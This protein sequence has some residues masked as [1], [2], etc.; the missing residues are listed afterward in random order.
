MRLLNAI[1]RFYQK[2]L[3]NEIVN[4][5][6]IPDVQAWDT[7]LASLGKAEDY[8]DASYKKYLCRIY[9]YSRF[10]RFFMNFTSFFVL[11]AYL[12]FLVKS[13]KTLS[14]PV[15]GKALFE[16]NADVGYKD[17]F[18]SQLNTEYPLIVS[19]TRNNLYIG[20]LCAPAKELYRACKK[21]HPF[22]FE[23][24]LWLVKELARHSKYL[25]E[26]N[27]TATIVY[28]NERNVAAPLLKKLYEDSGRKLISFMHGEYLFQLALAY[29]AFS[30]YYFWD[31]FYLH[32]FA[33]RER[34]T[35][36]QYVV[37]LP[38]R[39]KCKQNLV[40]LSAPEIF[41]TYYCSNESTQTITAL[42]DVI[43]RIEKKGL[44]CKVRPHPRD[45]HTELLKN[46][47]SSEQIELPESCSIND[48]LMGTMYPTGLMTTVFS[49]ALAAGK[50]II[51]DDITEPEKYE[52]LLKR[53]AIVF[54]GNYMLLSTLLDDIENHRISRKSKMDL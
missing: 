35:C 33:K 53:D 39:L 17:I 2:L 34:W 46:T 5:E 9:Y 7:Y 32:N 45:S 51:I 41:L 16:I 19:E 40:S 26:E 43:D 52:N 31:S 50:K 22:R 12:P 30:V 4:S 36:D 42:K 11:F 28:V 1:K 24:H 13:K 23:Y 48:S 3:K 37:Y 18:P 27:P 49:E 47:F 25:L 6:D 44:R 38:D 20:E 29:A 8:I 10:A 15:E 54:T 21:A 14:S